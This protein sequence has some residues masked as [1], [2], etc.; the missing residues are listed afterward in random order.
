MRVLW[1]EH[2]YVSKE[3]LERHS[4]NAINR[5]GT[6]LYIDLGYTGSPRDQR[7]KPS[8]EGN[9]N[10]SAPYFVKVQNKYYRHLSLVVKMYDIG[11]GKCNHMILIPPLPRK[12]V[13]I[14]KQIY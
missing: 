7:N 8:L 2:C 9:F 11:S 6:Q 12:I 5:R 4:H 3:F 10:S 14:L 1:V 13:V